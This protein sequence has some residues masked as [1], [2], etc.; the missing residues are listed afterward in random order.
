MV[1]IAAK[2][3]SQAVSLADLLLGQGVLGLLGINLHAGHGR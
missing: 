3:K 2:D 1:N